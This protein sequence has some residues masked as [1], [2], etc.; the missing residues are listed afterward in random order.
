MIAAAAICLLLSG[1]SNRRPDFTGQDINS[2]VTIQIKNDYGDSSGYIAWDDMRNDLFKMLSLYEAKGNRRVYSMGTMHGEYA[3]KDLEY[4]FADLFDTIDMI[5]PDV[6]LLEMHDD[7]YQ[8]YGAVDGPFEMKFVCGYAETKGIPVYGID[9][10]ELDDHIFENTNTTDDYRD[11]QFFYNIF[12]KVMEAKAGSTIFVLYG[13]EHFYNTIPRME[14]SGW[15]RKDI[16][17]SEYYK[18][19]EHESYQYPEKVKDVFLK[20]IDYYENGYV[21][22]TMNSITDER[23]REEWLEELA[24]S[25]TFYRRVVDWLGDNSVY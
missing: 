5:E 6:I 1:C 19:V 9:Y 13:G 10:W 2:G 14:L 18:H 15:Q 22:K 12:D 21:E 8:E 20:C 24:S 25:V 11:N 4:S 3:T 16:D 17:T 7:C 23:V